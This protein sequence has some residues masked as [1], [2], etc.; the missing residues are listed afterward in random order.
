MQVTVSLCCQGIL[1]QKVTFDT[2]FQTYLMQGFQKYVGNWNSIVG[3]R[4]TDCQ[5]S[6]SASTFFALWHKAIVALE[7]LIYLWNPLKRHKS[8]FQIVRLFMVFLD[9]IDIRHIIKFIFSE[10]ATQFCEIST[11][12]L[13]VCTVVKSKVEILQ[14][15]VVFSEYINF[16]V[17][18]SLSASSKNILTYY[19]YFMT[20][21]QMSEGSSVK[22]TT[23]QLSNEH[24]QLQQTQEDSLE[25]GFPID[26]FDS[27]EDIED[28]NGEYNDNNVHH[29]YLVSSNTNIGILF[30][31]LFWPTVRKNCSS[32]REK[33]LRSLEQFIRLII[34]TAV[35]R[36]IFETK[37]FLTCSW[38][39]VR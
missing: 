17:N 2:S 10:K 36:T 22:Q 23:K 11:L 12:L 30:P 33:L 4:V 38:R 6:P 21:S 16:K 13:T 19:F 29:Q 32:D 26:D 9:T 7:F 5:F 8:N 1:P 24:L 15:F 34:R 3:F 37:Y 18:K 14:N 20:G 28:I 35:V 39:F 31:K 25:R 27:I